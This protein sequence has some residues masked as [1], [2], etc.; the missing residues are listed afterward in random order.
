MDPFA[1]A[2]EQAAAVRRAEVASRELVDLYLARIE[3]INPE[4]NHYVLITPDLAHEMADAIAGEDRLAGAPCSIK[5][6]ISVAGYPT[7]LGSKAFE[8]LMLPFDGFAVSQ[9]KRAGTPILGKTNTS[10]FGTRPVVEHGLFPPARNPWN[11]EHTTGGSSGGA[12][13]AVAAG[14]CA[15]AQG[16]DGGGS[17]RI[18]ASCCGVV[19]F[20]PTRGAISPGPMFGERWAGLSTDGA[21]ARSV[22]DAWAA[23]RAMIGHLPGDPFWSEPDPEARQSPL[24]IG[25]DAAAGKLD[26]EVKA[27]VLDAGREC[28]RLGHHVEAAGPDTAPFREPMLVVVAAGVTSLPIP[29]PDE[30]S[31]PLNRRTVTEGAA[32]SAADYLRAV[33]A[34]RI[35]SRQ[36]V[37][38][39]GA[40]DVLLTPTLT[41]PAPRLNTLGVD[42][43]V[44]H[45]E[46]L[47]WLTYTYPYNCTGQPA[48]SLPLATHSSGLPIGVQLVGPPRGERTLVELARQ[49]FAGKAAR[50]P[51][52]D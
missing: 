46:Y 25:F 52:T 18:P 10:E 44:A 3:R 40:H 12:A 9:L 49:L 36:V 20:K 4:L 27:A 6:L 15:F 11:P 21:I 29:D 30:L 51:G 48:I 5:D 1:S 31:D 32:L 34:I 2:L 22:D 39:W 26:P 28:E 42:L 45:D 13:G 47:D 33:D 19:G 16:S 50:P 43:S 8:G 24:R 17:V 37:A 38:F 41:K 14:L 23:V 35:H 7:T